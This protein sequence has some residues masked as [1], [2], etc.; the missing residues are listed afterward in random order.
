MEY[1]DLWWLTMV[2]LTEVNNIVST[3]FHVQKDVSCSFQKKSLL[4]PTYKLGNFD[5]EQASEPLFSM[6]LVCLSCVLPMFVDIIMESSRGSGGLFQCL[7]SYHLGECFPNTTYDS[8]I[9]SISGHSQ[10]S[11]AGGQVAATLISL[12]PMVRDADANLEFSM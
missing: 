7:Y 11:K 6:D 4:T 8:R 9:S 5:K 12:V 1:T 2:I 3:G 10:I